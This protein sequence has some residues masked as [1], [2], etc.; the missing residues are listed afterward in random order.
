MENT[1]GAPSKGTARQ[2]IKVRTQ[3]QHSSQS[4]SSQTYTSPST[5]QVKLGK[6]KA[7]TSED[8]VNEDI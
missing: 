6:R 4:A 5:S 1:S 2:K 8:E 7:E 3:G